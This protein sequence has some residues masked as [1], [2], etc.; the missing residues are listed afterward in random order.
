M[1]L[2][3]EEIE[4][5]EGGLAVESVPLLGKNGSILAGLVV[6]SDPDI[7]NQ[8]LNLILQQMKVKGEWK[9]LSK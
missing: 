5:S 1:G 8:W 9:G 6:V 2:W 7:T 4:G 3:V